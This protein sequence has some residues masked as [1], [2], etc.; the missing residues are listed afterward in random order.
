[1]ERMKNLWPHPQQ[2]QCH[3]TFPR[4]AT[5]CLHGVGDAQ[6][7]QDL[8]RMHVQVSTR[9]EQAYPIRWTIDPSPTAAESYRLNMASDG[10]EIAA[11][12]SAGL[13]Y[14]RQTLLNIISLWGPRGDWPAV[15]IVDWP[16]YRKRSF[17]VD[18][19]RSVFPKAMLQRLV[20][21]LARLK[22]NRLHLHL[23][24]D[25]LCGLRFDDLPF[26]HDNPY[27]L[28]LSDLAD[29]AAYAAP[30]HVEVVPE[31]ESW[32][33]VGSLV[34]H[35][36]E[37]RGGE[38]MYN[39]SSLLVGENAFKMIEQL[40]RQVVSAMP[41]GSTIHFGLDEA[42]WFLDPSM[43]KDYAT[44]DMVRQYHRMLGELARQ[45]G[46]TMQMQI[47]ADHG[48][49]PVP[50]ELQDDIIIEPWQYWYRNRDAIDAA[51]AKYSHLPMKWMMSAGNGHV[52][53][54]GWQATRHW[55]QRAIDSDNCLGVNITHWADNDIAGHFLALFAGAYFAWNPQAP[56]EFT[57]VDDYE[58]FDL[59]ATRIMEPWQNAFRD[60]YPDDLRRD[61][62]PL[63]FNGHYCWGQD[64]LK[65]VA[66]TAPAAKTLR[67]HDFLNE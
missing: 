55:C 63:V 14:G 4:P 59:W 47:W 29:L 56:T 42:K 7:I 51:V 41:S 18:L 45:A 62:G 27:A 3:G 1:M 54:G 52:H 13:A 2:M 49:R 43:P 40:V 32:G 37:L 5:V 20:R 64:H 24:D 31:I 22:M 10:A 26:G 34:Y 67:G 35:R 17:M 9:D 28:S 23:L 11:A 50:E 44:V 33:H 53:G 15:T 30:Y 25:E 46:K 61:A 8:Q 66:P 36:P 60:A 39:G 19:G 16:A 21:V 38:G 58:W 48:G 65:P 6:F 57:A 12:D